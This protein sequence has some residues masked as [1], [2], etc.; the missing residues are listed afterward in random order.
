MDS[1]S[2][3][4]RIDCG[5]IGQGRSSPQYENLAKRCPVCQERLGSVNGESLRGRH[6]PH[7]K[8]RDERKPRL[9][10]ALRPPLAHDSAI[11]S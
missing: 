1:E 11:R 2:K 5:K 8:G 3:E 9:P 6:Q 7:L 10:L 4:G